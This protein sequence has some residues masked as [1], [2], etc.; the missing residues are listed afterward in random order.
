MQLK[1]SCLSNTLALQMTICMFY[2]LFHPWYLEQNSTRQGDLSLPPSLIRLHTYSFILLQIF[3]TYSAWVFV[4]P[5]PPRP[6]FPGR[7]HCSSFWT[8]HGHSWVTC[9]CALSLWNLSFLR[10]DI[11]LLLEKHD[12]WH[13]VN[14]QIFL[15]GKKKRKENCIRQKPR[16]VT[17]RKVLMFCPLYKRVCACVLGGVVGP[18]LHPSKTHPPLEKTG[19]P[20]HALLPQREGHRSVFHRGRFPLPGAEN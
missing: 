5:Y 17:F 2:S 18:L 9:M 15:E 8:Q 3:A 13:G 20:Q 16:T 10:L 19:I 7:V 4:D 6:N 12:V 11:F 14:T 1:M